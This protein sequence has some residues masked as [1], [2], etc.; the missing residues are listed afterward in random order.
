MLTAYKMIYNLQPG[1]Y[2]QLMHRQ[3]AG[4]DRTT[5]LGDGGGSD[6]E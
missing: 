4:R 2:Y 5:I 6:S 3:S 1:D